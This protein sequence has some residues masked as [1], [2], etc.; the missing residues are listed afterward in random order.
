MKNKPYIYKITMFN[1]A[2][3]LWKSPHVGVDSTL[4]A[5]RKS[6]RKVLG[7]YAKGNLKK[8]YKEAQCLD[9]LVRNLIPSVVWVDLLAGRRHH[10]TKSSTVV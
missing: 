5:D 4:S 6:L 8:A 2:I 3:N 9:I 7:I 10:V 1:K